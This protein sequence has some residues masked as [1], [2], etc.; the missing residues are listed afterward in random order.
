MP[1]RN[2]PPWWAPYVFIGALIVAAFVFTVQNRMTPAEF[3]AFAAALGFRAPTTIDSSQGSPRDV[4]VQGDVHVED[5]A[6]K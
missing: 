2:T 6:G 1:A 3:L 5:S 4:T